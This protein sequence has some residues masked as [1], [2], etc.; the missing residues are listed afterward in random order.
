MSTGDVQNNLRK[1]RRQLKLIRY[2]LEVNYER[3]SQGHVDGFLTI[4]HYLMVD[5]NTSLV[6]CIAGMGLEFYAK[7]DL[8]FIEAMYKVLRELISYKPTLTKE[9]FFSKGFGERK[10]IMCTEI[11]AKIHNWCKINNAERSNNIPLIMSNNLGPKQNMQT[12]SDNIHSKDLVNR[13]DGSKCDRFLMEQKSSCSTSG[14]TR[15]PYKE[16]LDNSEIDKRHSAQE[17]IKNTISSASSH[18][19]VPVKKCSDSQPLANESDTQTMHGNYVQIPDK[20]NQNMEML[21]QTIQTMNA[22]I[23]QLESLT[24]NHKEI[25]NRLTALETRLAAVEREPRHND[26]NILDRVLSLENVMSTVELNSLEG[27]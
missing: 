24:L 11:V 12:T 1:L 17:D 3:L 19:L 7:T 9:Q 26:G 21:Y 22:R 25:D 13:A 8:R 20:N 23:E 5:Y 18:L 16:I 27:K 14:S 2:P 15:P 4:Y 6:H 10:I